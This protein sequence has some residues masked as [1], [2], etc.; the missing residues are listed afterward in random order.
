MSV[1]L[2]SNELLEGFSHHSLSCL[3]TISQFY[4]FNLNDSLHDITKDRIL[5]GLFR[6]VFLHKCVHSHAA[7]TG[8]CQKV[9]FA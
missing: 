3:G 2:K 6:P 7:E 4:V 5:N 1:T 9:D 8:K